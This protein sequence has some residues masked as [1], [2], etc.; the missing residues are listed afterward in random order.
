[1]KGR[2]MLKNS[3]L[4]L[5]VVALTAPFAGVAMAGD[6]PNQLAKLAGVPAGKYTVA[7]LIQL[8]EARREG[9]KTTETFILSQGRDSVSRSDKSDASPVSAGAVQLARLAGVTPGVYSANELIRLQAAISE[10]DRQTIDFILS[11]SDG[12]NTGNDIGVVTPG[13]AQ[14][15]ASLGLDPAEHTTAELAALYLESIS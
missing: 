9:D 4:A 5:T 10:G 7:Q 2:I 3:I 12:G 6:G 14:L 13:K 11:G 15:A 8:Q 1:M